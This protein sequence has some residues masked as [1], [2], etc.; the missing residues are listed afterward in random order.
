MIKYVSGERGGEKPERVAMYIQ[1]S[2]EL[3]AELFRAAKLRGMSVNDFVNQIIAEYLRKVEG[4]RINDI[5]G[6][7]EGRGRK[8]E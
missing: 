7:I 8:P 2:R 5:A 1:I 3:K 6:R 4:V